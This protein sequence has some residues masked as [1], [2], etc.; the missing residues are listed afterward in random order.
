MVYRINVTYWSGICYFPPYYLTFTTAGTQCLKTLPV[1][2]SSVEVLLTFY[3]STGYGFTVH[4]IPSTW[5]ACSYFEPSFCTRCWRIKS[6]QHQSPKPQKP[7]RKGRLPH[8][9]VD[10]FSPKLH[11]V[12]RKALRIFPLQSFRNV[13]TCKSCK[14][15]DK[16]PSLWLSRLKSI[17]LLHCFKLCIWCVQSLISTI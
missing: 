6:S 14:N 15:R 5:S 10:Y 12:P 9:S 16:D 17:P 11:Y 1:Q 3:A 13:K 4:I 7:Q 8:G 2:L